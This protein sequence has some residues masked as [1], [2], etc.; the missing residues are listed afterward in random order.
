[1]PSNIEEHGLSKTE[2]TL[3]ERV[4]IFMYKRRDSKIIRF[5][6]MLGVALYTITDSKKFMFVMHTLCFCVIAACIL[7][8]FKTGRYTYYISSAAVIAGLSCLWPR[9][10]TRALDKWWKALN[11]ERNRE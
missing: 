1:M 4:A 11:E 7:M 3:M 6:G 9:F 10:T 8:A 2:F 5:C